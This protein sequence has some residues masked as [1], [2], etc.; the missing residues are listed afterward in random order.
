MQVLELVDLDLCLEVLGSY[1]IN[2]VTRM[3][4]ATM[5]NLVSIFR[6]ACLYVHDNVL[7]LF[8]LT[9]SCFGIQERKSRTRSPIP[10]YNPVQSTNH[11]LSPLSR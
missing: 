3:V 11:H 1:E 7:C 5:M 9:L 4:T 10:R 6:F 8:I 2:L